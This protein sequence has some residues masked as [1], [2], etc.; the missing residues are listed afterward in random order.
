MHT[1]PPYQLFFLQ[2]RKMRFN[3]LVISPKTDQSF[4]G[5]KRLKCF[6]QIPN[7]T[8]FLTELTSLEWK[9]KKKKNKTTLKENHKIIRVHIAYFSSSLWS[10]PLSPMKWFFQG[11]FFPMLICPPYT[12][13][14]VSRQTSTTS[15]STHPCSPLTHCLSLL[16]LRHLR[17]CFNSD[18]MILD[19]C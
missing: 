5:K 18:G 19:L 3:Y 14:K 15:L 2:Q 4:C 1:Q 16:V 17:H 9:Q 12:S 11:Y 7:W 6:L 13:P 8:I 10:D